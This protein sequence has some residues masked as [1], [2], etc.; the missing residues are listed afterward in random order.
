LQN[1][2]FTSCMSGMGGGNQ[3]GNEAMGEP[4][5]EFESV[6]TSLIPPR[7]Y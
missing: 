2:Q 1:G 4:E 7:K 5:F 3:R 6:D